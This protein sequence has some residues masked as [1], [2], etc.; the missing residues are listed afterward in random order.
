MQNSPQESLKVCFLMEDFYP[1]VHGAS[2]QI[3]ILGEKLVNTGFKIFVLTRKIEPIHQTREDI[4][5]IHVIRVKPAIGANRFGKYLMML[6]SLFQLIAMRK[7]IDLI[8]VSDIK[9]LGII[10]IF[11][12][13]ILGIKCLLRAESCGEMDGSFAVQNQHWSSFFIKAY[14]KVR[15]HILKRAQGFLSISSAITNELIDSDVPQNLIYQITNGINTEKFSPAKGEE[16]QNL[17]MKLKLGEEKYFLYTGRLIR[18]KGLEF[19][20]PAWKK[21]SSKF[22]GI[23]LLIVGSGQGYMISNEEQLRSFV[24]ENN[25]ESTVRFEGNVS[26]VQ[27]YLKACDY[28][29]FP[30]QTEALG[31]SLVEAL[32]CEL[33]S[34]ATE[35][36]GIVDIIES[37]KNGLLVPYGD[38]EK[39]FQAMSFLLSN[40]QEVL[41]YGQNGRQTVLEKF[42]IDKIV[43]Q[44]VSLFN[45]IGSMP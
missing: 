25:L 18:G 27:D 11:A 30:T 33:P 38:E 37:Q 6:P 4:N 26:N 8:I 36:G 41:I 24:Q 42:D 44:Y 35:V 7:S 19:L 15:N 16:R 21:L 23:N 10:G 3:M 34:I 43:D 17:R 28:F 12:S 20:M 1:I 45:K 14:I 13:K 39:L 22:S 32:S 2:S 9:A 5:G 31:L 40:D 29:V